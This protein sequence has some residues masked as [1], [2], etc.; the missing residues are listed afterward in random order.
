[1]RI[2]SD[3]I[4]IWISWPRKLPFLMWVGIIQ[5]FA[6]L[7]RKGRGRRN[8]PLLFCLTLWTETSHFMFS[9]PRTGIYTIGFP[10]SQAFRCELNC[11]TVCKSPCG[12]WQLVG[13]LS[14]Y[15]YVS[16]LLTLDLSIIYLPCFSGKPWLIQG[17]SQ[18]RISF[19]VII[20]TVTPINWT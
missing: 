4:S 3:E 1:M 6:G 11:N 10:G 14:L 19:N 17:D 7:N 5:Y 9:F 2:F 20:T 8:L 12:R 16:Q 13:L 18:N 15:N